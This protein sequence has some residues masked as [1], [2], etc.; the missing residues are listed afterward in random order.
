MY[1]NIY[2]DEMKLLGLFL[3]LISSLFI[4]RFYAKYKRNKEYLSFKLLIDAIAIFIIALV[5][6]FG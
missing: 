6:L 4:R 5:F 3:L 2:I 1:N